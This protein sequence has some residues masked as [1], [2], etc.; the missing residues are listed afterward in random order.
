MFYKVFKFMAAMAVFMQGAI[1]SI[2]NPSDF[3]SI[4]LNAL[5]TGMVI[6]SL[7]LREDQ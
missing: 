2:N 4:V 3:G 5:V 7:Y 6:Y 1:F